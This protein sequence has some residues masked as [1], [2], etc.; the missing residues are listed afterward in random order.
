MDPA[1]LLLPT[2]AMVEPGRDSSEAAL[3]CNGRRTPRTVCSSW[4]RQQFAFEGQNILTLYGVLRE[5][6]F[7]VDLV[8]Q[9]TQQATVRA[10]SMSAANSHGG[11][12]DD[13]PVSSSTAKVELDPV[14]SVDIDSGR[15]P[16]S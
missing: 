13:M 7:C 15:F 2:M 5:W 6:S 4:G 9:R 8:L 10:R 14:P 12:M 16:C 3:S 1:M 11:G